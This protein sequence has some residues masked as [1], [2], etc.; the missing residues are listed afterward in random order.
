MKVRPIIID[1]PYIIYNWPIIH[2]SL[3]ESA[4]TPD[5]IEFMW[6]RESIREYEWKRILYSR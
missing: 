1:L 6:D 2:Q 4:I 3:E 5:D